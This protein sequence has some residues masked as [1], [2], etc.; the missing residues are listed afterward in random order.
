M[1]DLELH[2][3]YRMLVHGKTK[4]T[5][6]TFVLAMGIIHGSYL[7]IKPAVEKINATLVRA[8]KT[9]GTFQNMDRM[10]HPRW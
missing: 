9:I 2:I 3:S 8:D 10:A 7:W 6:S 4:S 1:V 5:Y